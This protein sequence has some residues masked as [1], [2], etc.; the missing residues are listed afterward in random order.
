[1]TRNQFMTGLA[2]LTWLPVAL[3]VWLMPAT[4]AATH[5]DQTYN[6]MVMLHG[7]NTIRIQV[8]VYDQSGADCWVSDGC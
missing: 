3:L 6:Y 2:W 1:M 8:P 5:V 7:S 4:A